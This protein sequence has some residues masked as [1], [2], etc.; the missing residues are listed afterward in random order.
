MMRRILTRVVVVVASSLILSGLAV[1][2]AR[3]GL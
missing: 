1:V 3:S 2:A